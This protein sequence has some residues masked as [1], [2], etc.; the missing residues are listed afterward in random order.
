MNQEYS[1]SQYHFHP[2]LL[3]RT[4]ACN[5]SSYDSNHWEDSLDDPL[6]RLAI[7]I[8]SQ[9][10]YQELG[11]QEAG[12]WN[13]KRF[14]HS[15]WKYLN[16]MM[17]RP[18]P[19]G[20]F[21]GFT[22][23]DWANKSG[24][25]L[26]DYGIMHIQPDFSTVVRESETLFS[27]NAA[28]YKLNPTIY[29][30]MNTYRYLR[31]HNISSSGKRTFEVATVEKDEY[32]ASLLEYCTQPFLREQI[33]AWISQRFEFNIED[34]TQY[35]S[36]LISAQILIRENE[37][38]ICGADRLQYLPEQQ[39]KGFAKQ[40]VWIML[41]KRKGNIPELPLEQMYINLER[42]VLSGTLDNLYQEPIVNGMHCLQHL[43]PHLQPAG[44]EQF[45][46]DFIKKYDRQHKLLIEVLDPEIGIGYHGLGNAQRAPALLRDVEVAL[47]IDGKRPLEW[48]PVHALLLDKWNT[49]APYAILQLE[50]KDISKLDS[51]KAALPNSCPVVFRITKEGLFIEQAGGAT[52]TALLGR[53]TPLN[54]SVEMQ[55]EQI[56]KKEEAANSG[57]AFAEISYISDLHTANIDRRESLYTYEIPVLCGSLLPEE[58]QIQLNDLWVAVEHNEIMLWSKRLGCRII[59]RLSSAFNYLRSDLPVFRFLC[60][61]QHQ[62]LHGNFSFDMEHFFPGLS[63]YPR[64]CYKD[65]IL[66]LAKWIVTSKIFQPV[67]S[68]PVEKQAPALRFLLESL[69]LPCYIS[70]DDYDNQLVFNLWNDTDME[71]LLALIKAKDTMV[72]REYIFLEE[73]N[74][75]I[76]TAGTGFI[77]QFIAVLQHDRLV[78]QD[79]PFP[80]AVRQRDNQRVLVPGSEWLYYKL[81]I[82]PVRSN[83]L[84]KEYILPCIHGLR[85]QGLIKKWFFIRYADP[86]HHLRIRLHVHPKQAGFA[87]QRFEKA[88]GTLASSGMIQ[89]YHISTY[90]RELERYT[91]ELI[92]DCED[93][94]CA[95]SSLIAEWI[96]LMPDDT[97]LIYYAVVLPAVDEMLKAFGY[98]Y[99]AAIFLFDHSFRG[100]YQKSP[101]DKKQVQHKSRELNREVFAH[102]PDFTIMPLK[103]AFKQFSAQTILLA[104]KAATVMTEQQRKILFMDLLHMHLN[105]LLVTD[106]FHQEMILYYALWKYYQSRLYFA[107]RAS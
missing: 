53:F 41:T 61:L 70:L 32:I 16:R 95:G 79:V 65:T 25:I 48:T 11:K 43:L 8:A 7:R 83:E 86:E 68:L 51:P 9:S 10:L 14:Q 24:I 12:S 78:Y 93:W 49:S 23:V 63:F 98:D 37:V 50:E 107:T 94:F 72:I 20:L 90:E 30:V 5:F 34:C 19:F 45:K 67:L 6:F 36:A 22:V 4:P 28:Y 104:T 59:P 89:S 91:P 26:E 3:L 58:Q 82:H 81:Y 46:T 92:E 54:A 44:L 88:M 64:V 18:T 69:N 96:R 75:V 100:M 77:H 21:A 99:E 85:A 35:I 56:A 97:S 62:G 47:S 27:N 33:A 60:D 101:I 84:L 105:R 38:N 42:P 66:H 87:L 106:S 57:V 31:Y 52:A 80:G 15:L 17:F 103:K 102:A 55:A 13:N 73:K 76:D 71:N 40:S 29:P 39:N 74:I 1:M 2:L